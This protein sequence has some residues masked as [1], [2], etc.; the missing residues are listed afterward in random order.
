MMT[1]E[2]YRYHKNYSGWRILKN[3]HIIAFGENNGHFWN[4]PRSAKRALD[5]YM[6]DMG[7]DKDGDVW[8]NEWRVMHYKGIVQ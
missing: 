1:S 5:R 4:S 3:G 6:E 7:W 2:V 8:T